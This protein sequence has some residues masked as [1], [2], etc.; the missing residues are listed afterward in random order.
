METTYSGITILQADNITLSCIPSPSDITLQWSYNGSD[1]SSLPHYQFT[2]PS[3]NH[4]LT[5]THANVTD[6]GNYTCA[7]ILRNEVIDEQ[8]IILTVV[9][10]EYDCSVLYQF[11]LFLLFTM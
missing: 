9:P 11:C 6:S 8:T 2:P 7:F 1:I 3:L 10:S 4:D 5:I